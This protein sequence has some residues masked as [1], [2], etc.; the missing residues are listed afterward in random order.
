MGQVILGTNILSVQEQTTGGSPFKMSI[1]IEN[2]EDLKK[3]G[4]LVKD[5]NKFYEKLFLNLIFEV[6]KY[7]IRLT[8]LDTGRLRGGWTGILE[9]YRVDYG[10]QIKDTSLYDVFKGANAAPENREYH[11]SGAEVQRGRSESSYEDG[12]PSDTEI[13]ITNNVPYKDAQ[14]FGTSVMP[15]KHFTIQAVYKGEF[16]FEQ[17]LDKWLKKISRAG[18][19]VPPDKVP[20][21]DI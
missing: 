13:S 5:F 8:P 17:Q 15:G 7:L 14:D 2:P 4:N 3:M 16:L 19:I 21:I 20:E 18:A 11:F 9:K 10:K 1:K 12:L 6:H